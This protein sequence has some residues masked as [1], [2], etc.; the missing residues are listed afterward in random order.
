M[1]KKNHIWC[2]STK[3]VTNKK[4]EMTMH[5]CN[6]KLQQPTIQCSLNHLWESPTRITYKNQLQESTIRIN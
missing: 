4:T 5:S 6:I 3:I 2:L 1:N